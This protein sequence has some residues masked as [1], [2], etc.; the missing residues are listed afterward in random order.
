MGASFYSTWVKKE[1]VLK[2]DWSQTW[3]EEPSFDP[4]FKQDPNFE[5]M[6]GMLEFVAR[7]FCKNYV[8]HDKDCIFIF[9][10]DMPC[11]CGMIDYCIELLDN[12]IKI[13]SD[14][15]WKA[16]MWYELYDEYDEDA[17]PDL[18]HCIQRLRNTKELMQKYNDY[19]PIIE[20]EW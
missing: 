17:A 15:A 7:R 9:W 11:V 6:E 14:A 20:I 19:V 18:C 10:L 12:I 4:S 8:L 3:I 2:H 16:S 13:D 5:N 1:E